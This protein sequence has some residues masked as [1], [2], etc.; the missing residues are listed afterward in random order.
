MSIDESMFEFQTGNILANE[1]ADAEYEYEISKNKLGFLERDLKLLECDEYLGYRKK[2]FTQKDS[3]VMAKKSEK[4][5]E[6][7]QTIKKH[8]EEVIPDKRKRYTKIYKYIDMLKS[9][10]FLKGQELKH[11]NLGNSS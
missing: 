4:V 9:N 10:N 2:G 1:C 5:N 8:T 3:E 11:L 7:Y 6:I